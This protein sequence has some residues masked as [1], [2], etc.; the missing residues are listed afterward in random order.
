MKR[1]PDALKRL[2]RDP[3][4]DRTRPRRKR[5]VWKGWLAPFPG[6]GGRMEGHAEIQ[7]KEGHEPAWLEAGEEI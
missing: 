3:A 4:L 6:C 2:G 7:V 1:K 5:W